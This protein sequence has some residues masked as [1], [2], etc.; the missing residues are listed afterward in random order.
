MA[1]YCRDC[2]IRY[3]G[4][5]TAKF[6]GGLC[7]RGEITTMLCEGCGEIID[8]DYRGQRITGEYH[9]EHNEK[10][11]VM[12]VVWKLIASLFGGLLF[13]FLGFI[14]FSMAV[15]ERGGDTTYKLVFLALFSL[16]L[17]LVWTANNASKAWRR[18]LI[19]CALFSLALPLSSIVLS[20]LMM[21]ETPLGVSGY[22]SGQLI[23]SGAFT[24]F[25]GFIGL[26]MAAIFLIIGLLI[27]R[28]NKS[29][30]R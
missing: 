25:T 11:S 1:E 21:S 17:F 30:D 19:G 12:G 13:T 10:A 14:V 9:Y 16:S 4:P 23:G 29:P 26:F 7:K 22:S 5:E 8:V 28:D 15:G 3:L 6:A 27:G 2:S 18:L 20:A 24:M